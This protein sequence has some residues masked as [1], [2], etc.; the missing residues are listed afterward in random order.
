MKNAV[1][2]IPAMPTTA[3]VAKILSS[4][5]GLT[6][7]LCFNSIIILQ[8]LSFKILLLY[9]NHTTFSNLHQSYLTVKEAWR[10]SA[11]AVL[12]L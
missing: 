12:R 6:S 4:D 11:Q 5:I 10:T 1:A 2:I 9:A 3:I 8:I 7:L